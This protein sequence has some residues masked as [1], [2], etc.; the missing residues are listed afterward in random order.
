ARYP[1][2]KKVSVFYNPDKPKQGVLVPG[3]KGSSIAA[4]AV[5]GIVLLV[6]SIMGFAQV[7]RNKQT[8]N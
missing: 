1:L 7:R 3:V 8:A 2:G 6:L 5:G 4:N